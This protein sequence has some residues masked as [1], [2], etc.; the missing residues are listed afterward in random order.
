MEKIKLFLRGWA[1]AIIMCLL[2]FAIRQVALTI[3]AKATSNEIVKIHETKREGYETWAGGYKVTA[4]YSKAMEDANKNSDLHQSFK[5]LSILFCF[6]PLIMIK[7]LDGMD[8]RSGII[9]ISFIIN[10]ALVFFLPYIVPT[11]IRNSAE[12]T[13]FICESEYN[14]SETKN[15][16]YLFPDYSEQNKDVI[17]ALRECK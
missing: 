5:V 7:V 13:S 1:G 9:W 4:S 3:T 8:S 16:D 15:F 17:E 6:I 14:K 11:T 2:L 10:M 12:Y